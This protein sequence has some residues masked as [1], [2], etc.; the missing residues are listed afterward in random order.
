MHHDVVGAPI[1]TR[2]AQPRPKTD[3]LPSAAPAPT[4][5][6]RPADHDDPSDRARVLDILREYFA[7]D[8]DE[9]ARYEWLYLDNPHGRARTYLALANDG[10]PVGV[11]SL[12]PRRVQVGGRIAIGAI[13]GDAFVTPSFRRRGIVTALHRLALA[14]LD[15]DLSFMFGPPEPNNLKALLQA[16]AVVVG[17]VRRYR[18]PLGLA[19][20]GR[21]G[22][23]LAP[24]ASLLERILAPASARGGSLAP[25]GDAPDPRVDAVWSEVAAHVGA[26]SGVCPVRDAAF[27]AWRFG[28]CPSGRERGYLV[29]DDGAPIAVAAIERA[30]NGRAGIVDLTCTPPRLR[31][32]LGIVLDGCRDASAVEAQI[33]VPSPRFEA[34]L[35]TLGFVPRA[36]KAFQ[37][38]TK[39][40]YRDHALV[41]RAAG[42]F[43]MW[44]DGDVDKVV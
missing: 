33:H 31:R 29:L 36:T 2:A 12:F 35:A 15:E 11:T 42:W 10:R 39:P 32:A 8:E 30:P 44:G 14:A 19:G 20:L 27:Y 21:G 24:A 38:Q 41:T 23:A 22:A 1:A 5:T 16:G 26:T 40:S 17:A 28:R 25:L 34:V 13:G 7:G 6:V 4:Y 43:Y 3:E 37:V 9:R 18:R